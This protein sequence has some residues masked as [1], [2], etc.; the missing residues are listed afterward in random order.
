MKKQKLVIILVIL[1]LAGVGI[2]LYVAVR[3]ASKDVGSANQQQ[4][5]TTNS[6]SGSDNPDSSNNSDGSKF[7]TSSNPKQTTPNQQEKKPGKPQPNQ[8]EQRIDPV[9]PKHN[10]A[11]QSPASPAAPPKNNQRTAPQFQ[12]PG[13]SQQSAPNPQPNPTPNPQPQ[14]ADQDKK[15]DIGPP[16]ALE[17]LEL[18][19]YARSK[20][21]LKPLKMYEPLNRTAQWMANDMKENNYFSHYKPGTAIPH[22]LLKARAVCNAPAEN[23]VQTSPPNLHTSRVA[24]NAWMQSPPH[25]QSIMSSAYTLTGLGIAGNK[26]VE[27]FC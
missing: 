12:Q 10:P 17:I 4:K 26:I 21:N 11:P 14:P 24:F 27:H 8:K 6:N 3:A 19:N 13:N 1:I 16:D 5:T 18:I 20:E 23:L 2:G 15:Y 25:R 7:S 9:R 22:G